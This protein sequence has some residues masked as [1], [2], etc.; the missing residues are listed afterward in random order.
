MRALM[1]VEKP[2][3]IMVT[4][5]LTMSL[6]DWK[7]LRTQLVDNYPSWELSSKITDLMIQCQEHFYARDE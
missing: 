3:E 5:E 4:M 2:D 6:K 7:E 1:R